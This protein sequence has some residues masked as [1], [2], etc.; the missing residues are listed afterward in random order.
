MPDEGGSYA[1]AFYKALLDL[2]EASDLAGLAQQALDLVVRASPGRRGYLAILDRDGEIG[3]QAA[4]D[5]EG[6]DLEAVVASTSAGIV[7]TA[8]TSGQTVNTASAMLDER[9]RD[10]ESVRRH[11]LAAV[12]CVPVGDPAL[13][14]LVL[15]GSD[16]FS[17]ADI[18]RTETF[19]KH[20]APFADRLLRP[21]VTADPTEPWRQRLHAEAMIGRSEAI[22]E[23]LKQVVMVASIDAPALL[24]GPTGVGKTSVAQVIHRSSTRAQ[25]PFVVL[26]CAT[27]PSGLAESELFGAERGAHSTATRPIPG[28]VAAARGG[29]LVL[30]EIGELEPAVQAKLL[31][32]VQE[33][34]YWPLGSASPRQSECRI[35]AATNVDLEEAA[36]T[37]RFREDLFY[38]LS[39]F[40]IQIPPLSSRGADVLLLAEHFVTEAVARHQLPRVALGAQARASILAHAW[41]GNVRELRNAMERGSVVAATEQVSEISAAH[42][43]LGSTATEPSAGHGLA[44]QT[45]QFQGV[46]VRQALEQENGN[47]T[48]AA[49]RLEIHRSHLYTLMK[50]HGLHNP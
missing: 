47:V 22:A 48:A 1:A 23:M 26:N 2:G 38:R 14:V 25:E 19:A 34:T 6:A 40:Q 31:Q 28:K 9:F 39:V 43:G 11:A 18:A 50:V 32:L 45:R 12:L 44:A 42:L 7:R 4:Q 30:D 49:R 46:L 21:A 5:L 13:G 41:P 37:S 36:R 17:D 3:W 35:L 24:L 8:M 29:T 20:L 10:R 33:G 15:Q 27:L 16:P